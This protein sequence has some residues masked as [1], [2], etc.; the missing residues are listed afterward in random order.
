[1]IAMCAVIIYIYNLRLHQT[2]HEQITR[3]AAV[4]IESQQF[5]KNDITLATDV[6]HY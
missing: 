6:Q 3:I 4:I 2:D 1:M 5:L